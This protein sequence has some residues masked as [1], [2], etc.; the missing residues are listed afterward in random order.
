MQECV[1]VHTFPYE[2]IAGIVDEGLLVGIV[3]SLLEETHD[4]FQPV[5][6]AGIQSSTQNHRLNPIDCT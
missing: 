3:N 5:F 6:V 4:S 2:V 1:Y